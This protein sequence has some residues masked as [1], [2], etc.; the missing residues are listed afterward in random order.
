M[1]GIVG[2]I[3]SMPPEQALAELARMLNTAR[4]EDFYSSGWWSDESLGI[5]I[6][7]IAREGSFADHMP[8]HNERGDVV[9][10]FSG[11]EYSE[12]TMAQRMR[13]QGHELNTSC[14]AYLA[15]VYEDDASFPATLNGRFHGVIA[16]KRR[17]E[18]L[19]FNDRYGMHRVYYHE[20][21]NA[22]YF[23]CEAKAI[24]AV[25]PES[26]SI[27]PRGLGEFVA[28]GAVLENRTL[29]PQIHVLPQSSA[30]KFSNGRL[31]TRAT[32][33]S[34]AE[35]EQQE[36]LE[37]KAWQEELQR[38]F[39]ENL[40]R[41]FAAG[42]RIG[43]SLTGGLD[44]RMILSWSRRPPGSLPCYT[45]GSVFRENEDV[46]IARRLAKLCGQTH[47]VIP[48]GAEF[49]QDFAHYAARAVYLTDGC[50]DVS[51]A[52]D[53][54]LNEKVRT[55]APVRMTGNYGGEI[56]RGVRA[57]KPVEPPAGLFCADFVP[58]IRNGAGTYGEL[59]RAH[60]V[61]FS[62]FRQA[63]WYHHGILSLEQTQVS[64][65]SPFL[66]NDFVR[67]VFRAP[68]RE[69]ST[70]EAS[71]Q[72]IGAG[73][74]KLLDIPTDR[75]LEG[76]RPSARAAIRHAY[77]EFLFKAEYAYDMG[78]PQW[79]A[80]VDHIF[81]GAHL[82]RMFLGR[83]KVFHFRIWYRDTL[84]NYLRE[85]LL[86]GGSLSRSYIEQRGLQA[87]VEGHVKGNKNYTNAIH[88][89]LTLELIHRTLLDDPGSRNSEEHPLPA[90]TF[91][92]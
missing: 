38:V 35:W 56:L 36:Q 81:S 17:G 24:L 42:E 55:I 69:L 84:A 16:D 52:P 39:S 73:D 12:P 18:I 54:Y 60:P 33:F 48:A 13:S 1:P 92:A 6:G 43:M 34:P 88:Q 26:R 70:S 74:R 22:F 49:L 77:L 8:V 72:L 4:H 2:L 78:M 67:T 50:V 59:V 82:E 85:M 9:L 14:C 23:A 28:C 27:D 46:R 68:L 83:H 45:F 15:H 3:T 63:P 44:T 40:P 29:F 5:Y 10:V 86:D 41:Y 53:L 31:R 20:A 80:R 75:A 91:T 51:R 66:D 90:H 47:Q 7:W 76:S 79:I 61:T 37:R 30:W 89:A 58:H 32:Y 19:L 25:R 65:R 21:P 64:M 87:V 57:F 11:E 71:L 62:A